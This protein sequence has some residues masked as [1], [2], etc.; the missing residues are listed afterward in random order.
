[1]VEGNWAE[2]GFLADLST[3]NQKEWKR[4]AGTGECYHRP[5]AETIKRLGNLI[6]GDV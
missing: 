5:M 1:M 3:Y 2:L 6:N 4:S